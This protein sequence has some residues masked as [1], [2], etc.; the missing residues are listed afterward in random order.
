MRSPSNLFHTILI[1]ESDAAHRAHIGQ[2][3]QSQ[4]AVSLLVKDDISAALSYLESVRR[5]PASLPTLLLVDYQDMH[6]AGH[7]LL[8]ELEKRELKSC[9][10]V[11]ALSD[12]DERAVIEEAYDRGVASYFIKPRV[13]QE[14]HS[15]LNLLIQ[16][17]FNEVTL[18]AYRIARQGA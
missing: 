15:F 12:T 8:D 18:P 4:S 5:T 10:P 2:Y 13:Y 11:I 17:W 14:W 16:Y 7:T 3:L 9:I 1:V 6:R